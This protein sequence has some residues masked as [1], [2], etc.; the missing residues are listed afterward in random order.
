MMWVERERWRKTEWRVSE[1]RQRKRDV[2]G[3]GRGGKSTNKGWTEGER[4]WLF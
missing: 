1:G 3:V 2:N 4:D